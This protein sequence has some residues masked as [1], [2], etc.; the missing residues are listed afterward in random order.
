MY[1]IGGAANAI[2]LPAKLR[3]IEQQTGGRVIARF[4]AEQNKD[5]FDENGQR[6]PAPVKPQNLHHV[7]LPYEVQL[8]SGRMFCTAHR[9]A[10]ERKFGRDWGQRILGG[11]G[12][13]PHQYLGS[14]GH[15][16][17]PNVSIIY[18]LLMVNMVIQVRKKVTVNKIENGPTRS[19][20][21][22]GFFF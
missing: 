14:Y 5:W 16:P 6:H 18:V 19:S 8:N 13:I 1:F 21:R 3:H 15:Q 17:T 9:G 10:S 22:L 11:R 20:D 7:N 2:H 4:P 12:Q